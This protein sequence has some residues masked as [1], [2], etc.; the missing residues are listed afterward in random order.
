MDVDVNY[1]AV[2][3][4]ALSSMVVGAV[5]YAK[6]VFGKTWMSMVKLDEKKVSGK[7]PVALTIAFVLAL[8]MAYILAHVTFLSNHFFGNSFLQDAVTTAFWLWLGIAFVAVVTHDTFE[9]RRR[10]LTVMTVA[11]VLV[12]MVV[13]AV[14]IGLMPPK[15]DCDKNPSISTCLKVGE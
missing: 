10:K 3:L 8:I 12:T 14:I 13:M 2:L 9:Q 4:A 7:A 15:I 5:W 1:L 11:N 6:P